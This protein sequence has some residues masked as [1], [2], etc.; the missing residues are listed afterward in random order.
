MNKNNYRVQKSDLFLDDYD[1]SDW[2]LPLLKSD[3]KVPLTLLLEGDEGKV[4]DKKALK[5]LTQIHY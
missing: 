3:E 1:Y 4:K 5:I 2:F